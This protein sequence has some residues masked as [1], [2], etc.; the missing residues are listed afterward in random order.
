MDK[1]ILEITIY[2]TLP[3][4]GVFCLNWNMELRY[5]D[6]HTHAH[7]PAYG[8][9]QDAV[10]ARAAAI[11]VGMITVG[12]RKDTSAAAV[13]FAERHK[14]VWAAVGVHP[15]H[16]IESFHDEDELGVPTEPNRKAL[17]ESFDRSFFTEL[18][19][20]KK[21]VAVG[22]CGLDYFRLAEDEEKREAQKRKQREEFI[23]QLHFA[24]DIGKPLMIHCRD[25]YR[26][27][28]EILAENR[29]EHTEHPGIIHFFSGS[30]EEAKPFLDMGFYFTFGGAITFP[31]K[32]GGA[33][34][35]SLIKVMP[36]ER[37]L[38]ETDAPWVAPVPYRGTRNEAAY[39]VEVVKKIAEIRGISEDIIR[40]KI[41]ENTIAAFNVRI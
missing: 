30:E 39:V 5:F 38:S 14:N 10:A 8:T 3:N 18:A 9:E 26:D 27:L 21:V 12:T 16:A 29:M 40:K 11:G 33:D 17:G 1:K 36:V 2:H 20:S 25:A 6:S 23:A 15:G 28:A 35:A 13:A 19:K 31:Q 22:E 37:I 34:Y 41:L 7:F 32:K 4:G 24:R